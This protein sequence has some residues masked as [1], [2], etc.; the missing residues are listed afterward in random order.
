LKR[1][2]RRET[3]QILTSYKQVRKNVKKE[4]Q[5]LTSYKQIKIKIK[6]NRVKKEK[7]Y[8]HLLS[9]NKTN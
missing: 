8:K 2:E 4:I 7:K 6:I 1:K 5:I 3:T 9:T